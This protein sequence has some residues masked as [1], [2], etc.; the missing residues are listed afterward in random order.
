MESFYQ[1]LI[2]NPIIAALK[3]TKELDEALESQVKSIFLLGCNICEIGEIV[4]KTHGKKKTVFIHMDLM[5][6]IG[7]DY[8]GVK[9]LK[10]W[11][12]LSHPGDLYGQ[13]G[14]PLSA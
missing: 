9:F 14:R 12:Y 2:E 5:D 13:K 4:D 10:N 11:I 6:G 1:R 8:Y 3:S 7:R